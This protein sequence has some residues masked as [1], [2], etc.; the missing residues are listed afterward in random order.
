MINYSRAKLYNLERRLFVSGNG[1]YNIASQ[2]WMTLAHVM[3]DEENHEILRTMISELF[4][5]KN[6]ATPYMYHCIAEALLEGGLKDEAVK[7]IKDYWW[8][9]LEL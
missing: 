3:V 5:V 1:E 8:K 6:I 2:V 9:M 4:T 7:L